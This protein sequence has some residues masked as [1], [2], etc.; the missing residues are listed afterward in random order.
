MIPYLAI[1]LSCRHYTHDH[2][3]PHVAVYRQIAS[4]RWFVITYVFI[5]V[6]QAAQAILKGLGRSRDVSFISLTGL[7]L[8]GAIVLPLAIKGGLLASC[9]GLCVTH[10]IQTTVALPLLNRAGVSVP[11]LNGCAAIPSAAADR[12]TKVFT[13]GSG[14]DTSG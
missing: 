13:S 14:E 4:L 12:E 3:R 2:P 6:L 5:Y 1:L 9:A 7:V 11:A 8:H 10:T